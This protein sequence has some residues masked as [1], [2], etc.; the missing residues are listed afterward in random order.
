MYD[1]DQRFYFGRETFAETFG[2][3]PCVV[4]LPEGLDSEPS[5]TSIKSALNGDKVAR[6]SRDCHLMSQS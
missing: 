4:G 2:G 6:K 5:F 1:H 3:M